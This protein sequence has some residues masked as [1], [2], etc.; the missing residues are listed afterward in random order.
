[1]N[2]RLYRC[3]HDRRLAGVASGMAHYFDLD[4]TLVR[5]LWILSF[6]F[7]GFGLLAYI[8]LAIVVPLEPESVPVAGA[9]AGGDAAAGFATG[10]SGE[11]G[12]DHAA[13]DAS[14]AAHVHTAR[15]PGMPG[16][17]ATFVGFA[18]IL[19]GGLA[20]VDNVL[21]AWGDGRFLWPAF[22]LG[23]G[24]LLVVTSM[25]RQSTDQ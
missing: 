10:A 2:R 22:I 9:V 25:R 5:V 14:V 16:L 4:P 20:L 17:G 7:G 18:L 12:H 15:G 6:F 23:I 3:S 19:F 21:P 1:M 8:I 11:A 13:I 24:A